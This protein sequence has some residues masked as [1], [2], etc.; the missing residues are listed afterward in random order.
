MVTAVQ[1][2]RAVPDA[3]TMAVQAA[4]VALDWCGTVYAFEY[5]WRAYQFS[6]GWRLHG[7]VAVIVH[8]PDWIAPEDRWI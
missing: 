4:A 7:S 5:R 8:G 2:G 3:L 6:D 1:T